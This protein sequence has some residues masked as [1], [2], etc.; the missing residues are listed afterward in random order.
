[1]ENIIKQ[2]SRYINKTNKIVKYAYALCIP[3]STVI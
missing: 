2:R 1:M 3:T